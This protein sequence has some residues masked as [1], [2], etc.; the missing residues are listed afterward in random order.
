MAVAGDIVINLTLDGKDMTLKLKQGEDL[1]R[2]FKTTLD[3]TARSSALLENH[4]NSLATKFRHFMIMVASV[5]FAL[6]DINQIFLALPRAVVESSAE[7]ERLTK[8]M[9]G[10]STQTDQAARKAEALSSVN[11]VFNL[12]KNAPFEVKALTD[13]FVKFRTVG[14]S[15]SPQKL[16]TLVDS[17]AKFGGSSE[18]IHRAAIAIQQMVG[19]GVISMEELRQQLGEAVPDAIQRMAD[20]MGMSM[21]TLVKHISKGEVEAR[22]ALD[23]MFF[24]MKMQHEGAAAEMMQTWVGLAA[25]LKTQWMLFLK[26]IGDDGF[27]NKVKDALNGI[28]DAFDTLDMQS[29][30]ASM[31][32]WLLDIVNGI[33]S[34]IRWIREWGEVLKVVGAGMALIFGTNMIVSWARNIGGAL[35]GVAGAIKA[36]WTQMTTVMSS[37]A[38]KY[39]IAQANINTQ[40]AAQAIATQKLT[41]AQ[42]ALNMMRATS[43]PAVLIATQKQ[44][45]ALLQQEVA[46]IGHTIASMNAKAVAARGL[47]VALGMVTGPIGWITTA[48]TLGI[49]AWQLWGDSAAEAYEKSREAAEGG[50]STLKDFQDN[51][52]L[53]E[54]LKNQ[55]WNIIKTPEDATFVSDAGKN[56]SKNERLAEIDKQIEEVGKLQLK[57]SDNLE[58]SYR[59]RA[60]GQLQRGLNESEQ[61][62]MI[63][64]R[65][66][67][68]NIEAELEKDKAAGMKA[69]DIAK[70]RTEQ[71]KKADGWAVEAKR[72][73]L[74]ALILAET[75][76]F[77]NAKTPQDQKTRL[78]YLEEYGR[79]LD[80]L[81]KDLTE[82]GKIGDWEK[83]LG[84]GS[85]KPKTLTEMERALESLRDRLAKVK[86]E[87]SGFE[88]PE[89]QAILD[90]IT[91]GEISGTP[92]Q[93]AEARAL[94]EAIEKG[95][96]FVNVIKD[97]E[98]VEKAAETK[99][100]ATNA[101]LLDQG[102]ISYTLEKMVADLESRLASYSDTVNEKTKK[103]TEARIAN[104]KA[105]IAF[106]D[107]LDKDKRNE[108]VAEKVGDINRKSVSDRERM[109][110]SM[111]KDTRERLRQE[112]EIE[113]EARRKEIE[114]QLKNSV[115][116]QNIETAA[117]NEFYDWR[118]ARMNKFYEDAK[119]PLQKLKDEWMNVNDA[120]DARM[121]ESANTIVDAIVKATA[122]GK[123]EWKK[124]LETFLLDIYKLKIQQAFGGMITGSL[125]GI[126]DWI[127]KVVFQSVGDT[128]AQQGA[129]SAVTNA[130][131]QGA[132]GL[133]EMTTQGVKG[134]NMGFLDMIKQMFFKTTADQTAT[135][136]MVTLT[137]AANAAASALMKVA[138]VGG[139]GGGAGGIGD[140]FGGLF[141][142]SG[143]S[144]FIGDTGNIADVLA[145]DWVDFGGDFVSTLSFAKGG[146]MTEFG[147]L[148][149]RKY[150]KGG[151]AN[152]PQLAMYG[153]GSNPEAYVPLPDGRSIPVTMRGNNSAPNVQVNIINQT[154]QDVT[155]Q[156]Q[157]RFDGKAMILDVVLTAVNQPGSFRDGMRG[158][159]R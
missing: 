45:V 67:R 112:A 87:I 151:V 52:E 159:I 15:D 98:E 77:Q 68:N 100:R 8:L 116:A 43:Q 128:A 92:G 81:N 56:V 10:L 120:I 36:S 105:E 130:A 156:Q 30:A 101:T 64:H 136:A 146:I 123:V 91:R 83:V 61:S 6:L 25:R 16:Q 26:A 137:Q 29:F 51:L 108:K 95:Q 66:W 141:G 17:I 79:R 93:K 148:A 13:A 144:D 55:R 53:L 48:L 12:A 70:K 63:A 54:R 27:F 28:V 14:L 82:V 35:I 57:H 139:G 46:V 94:A 158:A 3:T 147:S 22:S 73:Q 119:T 155:A 37:G 74:K 23:R 133:T 38:A 40:V 21:G 113:I 85:D 125:E 65:Q 49:T 154:S 127:K 129:L 124:M 71:I 9:E 109:N 7:I 134:A 19:K 89:V 60:V 34:V 118:T 131:K 106:A 97:I 102:K 32:K 111:I 153:E 20:G 84:K 126:G 103:A 33:A 99:I 86:N 58:R 47:S 122:G 96:G 149:L 150:A 115:D 4:F 41:Q 78:A 107:Q 152:R 11:F 50:V 18:H 75:E 59:E 142:G 5:R 80:S 90:K 24:Q 62:I 39:A 114:E 2:K 145:N 88:R 117:W 1:L 138:Q 143:G 140:L 110:L 31:G 104:L 135:S 44:T 72:Q 121:A 69:D 76:A 157:T 42:A 132:V